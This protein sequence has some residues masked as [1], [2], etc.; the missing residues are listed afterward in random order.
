MKFFKSFI[1]LFFA[2]YYLNAQVGINT[3]TPLDGTSL[4]IEGGNQGVMINK[5]AL[6][7][8]T[9]NTTIPG[10]DASYEGLMVYNTSS[11]SDGTNSVLPGFYFWN[12]TEWSNVKEG[13]SGKTGWVALTDTNTSIP[14]A[15]ISV[16]A[17]NDPANY[18]NIPI[19]FEDDP[20]DNIIDTYA[21]TGYSGSDFFDSTTNT[22]TP[23][24]LGDAVLVRLQFTAVPQDNNS[25]LVI[26]LDIGTAGSPIIVY[27][28]TIPLLR[29]SGQTNRV[30]ETIMLYQLGT[31]VAN[32]AQL[33]A[34][35][36]VTSGS[37]NN[38]TVSDFSLVIERL[39][40][41]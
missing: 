4:H 15:G 5:V 6:T 12:G 32:G 2:F 39:S 31:F 35:Y 1:C 26:A 7:G 30:S 41:D 23:L 3:T 17:A 19:D 14:I 25:Y 13:G 9:D 8:R 38:C 11:V 21:P 16:S 18:T 37:V 24:A 27:Q 36:S 29:G 10:L 22:I 33:K 34:A 20:G 40:N 28:K